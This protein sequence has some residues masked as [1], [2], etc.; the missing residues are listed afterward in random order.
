M[1]GGQNHLCK[2][3][4]SRGP[5]L[6]GSAYK[7]SFKACFWQDPLLGGSTGIQGRVSFKSSSKACFW[8]DP[9]LGGSTGIQGR[10]S[11]KS[12]SKACF[13]QDPLLGEFYRYTRGDPRPCIP[14]RIM[15]SPAMGL[16]LGVFGFLP[17]TQTK[18]NTKQM[19][20]WF[21]HAVQHFA[22]VYKMYLRDQTAV[23]EGDLYATQQITVILITG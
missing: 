15:A 4:F 11:F 10:V 2:I 17:T 21:L 16:K 6:K 3:C 23:D 9:L 22:L 18:T 7:S 12:S 1:G 19:Q 13:W 8:Q 20:P 14:P 5:N